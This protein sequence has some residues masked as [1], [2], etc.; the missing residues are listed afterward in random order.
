MANLITV[1]LDGTVQVRQEIISSDGTN[2]FHRLTFSPGQDV[3]DQDQDVQDAC[4]AAN[5][6]SKN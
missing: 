2:S 3:S 4:A 6:F 5:K 1:D